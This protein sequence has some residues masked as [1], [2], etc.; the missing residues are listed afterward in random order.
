MRI[1][2]QLKTLI[3]VTLITLAVF[4]VA[5]R[6]VLRSSPEMTVNLALTY[7]DSRYRLRVLNPPDETL[8]VTFTGPGA[9]IDRIL[10][11]EPPVSWRYELSADVAEAAADVEQYFIPAREGFAHLAAEYRVTV[12]EVD[13]PQVAVAVDRI[14]RRTVPVRLSPDDQAQLA[15]GWTVEP[16]EVKV[17]ATDDVFAALADTELVAIPQLNLDARGLREGRVD[18][19]RAELRLN[20]P[21]A[22]PVTF[23]PSTVTVGDLQLTTLRVRRTLEEAVPVRILAAK[24]V[25]DEFRLLKVEPES[26][27]NLRIV[28]PQSEVLSLTAQDV[29]A[30]LVLRP[31]DRPTGS[32][33]PLPR[34]LVFFFP[35]H[36]GVQV[37]VEPDP[38]NF[39][40]ERRQTPPLPPTP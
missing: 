24:S 14:T 6:A 29:W 30:V 10:T 33:T 39:V 22:A 31:S 19:L 4:V 13:P 17:A 7:D 38:V 21:T 26:I 15:P 8:R 37:D 28:G 12:A 5:D 23:E 32:G 18:S 2:S 27:A 40:L 16:P 1:G 25:L 20:V 9:G 35:N 36:E 3:I 34:P 11:Q